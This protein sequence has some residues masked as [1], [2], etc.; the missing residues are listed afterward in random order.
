MRRRFYAPPDHS[1][2]TA[3]RIKE[4][5]G[6]EQIV[7]ELGGDV[8]TRGSYDRW[9]PTKCPL[10][11]DRQASA[12]VHRAWGLFRCHVCHDGAKDIFDLTAEEITKRPSFVEA[13][14]WI[15]KR[16]GL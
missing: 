13:K 9:V 12:S 15:V 14:D 7:E 16:F 6:I 5:V 8:T 11:E 3:E 2:L 4:L 1:T 10:H